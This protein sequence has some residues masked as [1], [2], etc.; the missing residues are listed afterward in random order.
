MPLKIINFNEM[1]TKPK[2][3][4]KTREYPVWLK[5]LLILKM[6]VILILTTGLTV[7]YAESDGQTTKLDLKIST[8]T[9]KDFIEE[10]ERQTDL[11]FMY[12]NN[13]FNVD[14]KIS[15][16][17]ENQTVKSVVEKM[18][19]GE[20]L[21]YELVNRFIV[22]SAKVSPTETQQ[23]KSITGKVATASGETLPGV[24]VVVQGTGKGTM[25]NIDGIF[26]ITD[27][28]E[29]T[30]LQ[31][32]F[33]GMRTQEIA[34][35]DQTT[36]DVILIE[37]AVEIEE[38]V[39]IGYGVARKRDLTGSIVSISGE[40]LKTSPDYNPVK[41]LQGKVPGLVMTN[42]G[43]AGGSP[44][45]RIRGV[46]TVNA[47]TNPL[48]VVDG[49][50]VDNI[51][52]VN[53][54]D[55][56]SIEVLKDPSSLAIFGVQGANG[57]IIITTKRADKG[58]L[59]V[60][61][62]GYAG[63]QVLHERDRLNLTNA[64]EFTMLYNEQLKN[65][66]PAATEWVP[67]L[68]GGGTD[69]Q[70]EIFNPAVITNHGVTVSQ[71][72]DKASSVLSLG[73]FLQD[74][75]V[76]YNS[77][78]RLNARWSGDYIISKVFKAGGNVALTRWDTDPAT[79]SV[80]NAAQALPTYFPYSPVED[81]NPENIGSY[82]TPSP[83]IQKDVPNP[84][85]VMEI[86]KGTAESYGYRTVGNVYGEVAFLKDFTFRATGY[87]D[88]GINM[89]S[90]YFPRFD[91]NNENS[92]SSHKSEKTS[93]SRNTGEYS[94]YQ[95][96]L[97]LNYNKTKD[98]HR[99][100]AMA[101]YTSRVQEAKGFNAG[102]DT[103]VSNDMWVVTEDFW[104]LNMGSTQNKTNSDFYEA[105][106]FISYLA[107]LNYSYA[108]KYLF[109]ATFRADGSSKFSPN[110]RWGYFP[111]IGLG[112]VVTQEDFMTDKIK[113][114]DY[115]KVKTSWGQLG[116]DKI[117]NYLWFPTINPKGQQV[118][119]DGQ[120]YYIPTVSNL[121]DDDIHWEVVTGFDAGFES[122]W[123]DR[124]LSLEVGFFTKTTSD[125]LAYVAPPIS[126]GAGYAITNAGSIRNRGV[127]YIISWRG[128]TGDF[129]YGIST[130]G[131]TLN[132]EVLSLGN[133][134]SDIVTGKYHR[135]SVG[136]PVGAI[137][138]YVQDGI[139]QNQSEI[140]SYFPASWTSHPGDIR[141]EDLNGDQKITDK[142]RE[143]IGSSIPTFTYGINL[144]AAF[145]N[146][147]FNIDFNG[148]YGNQ[149]INTKKL[150]TF[151][152]FNF[153]ET[154]LNRWHGEGTSDFEPAL[155]TSRGNNFEP[156][157]NLLESGAYFRIRAIQLGYSLPEKLAKSIG[158][159][160]FRI[161][162]NAQNPITFK[163]NSGYTPEIG[164]GILDGGID[165][166]NTYPL[167]SVYTAGL[168]VNF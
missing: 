62:D 145:K 52:F 71:S 108:D 167:P 132:N 42:T 89:G 88:I 162:I 130:N 152:Q 106:S 54:N 151:A 17:G 93:F 140:D 153:Y 91:V 72:G 5:Q 131:A 47:S 116:N 87:A 39:A 40:S 133:D 107:R 2:S 50:F 115:L 57:V 22:I 110:N 51:D 32:S 163:N 97:I 100:G 94:K 75:I 77:Y 80:S 134:D 149:I 90:N 111:S 168:T 63:V 99:I 48:Y 159:S 33:V 29:N 69:W 109:S 56:S 137:Y 15:V 155:N 11:S 59:A 158:S 123:F 86:N 43:A 68:L 141:Y 65:M 144:N 147:D 49:M 30:V 120:T 119:I 118:V 37:E 12:D 18:I 142:D 25:S 67:D 58:K 113:T 156:S 105:E 81:H 23:Q 31:F 36:I 73:Y 35:G 84:V 76:N 166:G 121:V 98:L 3:D 28:P 45:V 139:F 154:T 1:K 165:N 19:L 92:N 46:A 8:G 129:T 157:T 164:G 7:A 34:V 128:K 64:S 61:Y 55:I 66:N 102:A 85:A 124:R 4:G 27:I 104:M 161:F 122:Q 53:P 135:T 6:I 9:V 16:E 148:S 13:I 44:T 14:R 126:V 150:P 160:N 26:T 82:Y 117:G 10:I 78:Q 74:G 38:V 83:S 127:E 60:S 20:D 96:D 136:H 125:L 24:S 101:G 143:F 103:L 70:S 95:T 146:F 112:W 138:G 114:L 41:A 79:A 21:K